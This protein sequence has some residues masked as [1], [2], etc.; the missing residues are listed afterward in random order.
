MRLAITGQD[1]IAAG[2]PSGPEIGRRL[3]LA[4]ERRLDGELRDGRDAE[5]E[6]ALAEG[7]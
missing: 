4:L 7:A 2:I 5:I 6:A 3:A 1:L